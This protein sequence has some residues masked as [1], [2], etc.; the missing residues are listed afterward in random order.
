MRPS[1]IGIVL[2][3]TSVMAC[4]GDDDPGAGSNTGG[5]GT[6]ATAGNAGSGGTSGSGASAGSGGG[7][8]GG[9]GA[10]G[11]SA[12]VDLC[13]GL[14]QDKDAHPMTALAKPALGESV[15]DA[16]FGTTIRRITSVTST[17]SS[18]AIRPL[19][20]T[21]SAWNADE[22]RLILYSVEGGGHGLYDGKTYAFIENLEISPPDLEQVYWHTSDPDILY[23]VEDTTLI[24]YHVSTHQKEPA[25]EFDFCSGSASAGADPMFMSWDSN[26][27]GLACG[28]QHFIW[29]IALGQATG[30]ASS[31]DNSP[32]VAP[33]G[34]F[35]YLSDTG[36]VTDPTLAVVR[37]LDLTE[38]YGHASLGQLANGHDTW[39]GVVYDP[40]P[41]GND[42]IGTL[43]TFDLTD[44]SS[45]V[46]I[47]PD[48][49]YPYPPTA[50]LSGM[51][52]RQ[53]GWIFVSTIG[54][55]SGATLLADENLIADTNTGAV[56]RI[57]RHRSYGKD[58]T[59]LGEPY[60][61][62]PHTTPSPSGTRAVFASDW[63]DGDTVDAYVVELPS[64]AP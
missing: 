5:G 8:T 51:A 2:L 44:G 14:V 29:D 12:P 40:G 25:G 52:Y 37:T 31:S 15:T 45:Q 60:W 1:V 24:R 53:R 19:Y 22:S 20:S 41:G 42:D 48:T 36:D 43:V 28:S 16:E 23:Y 57:G 62:E 38:P 10:I 21:V 6:G 18:P 46:I 33:S 13:A 47:G 63:G 49:G 32:Q 35:A 34:L 7:G 55:H 17:G 58:N 59:K 26:R 61:A 3:S 4:G 11:G 64:Y 56:C 9:A 39:N 30:E 54:D 27:L 50:H